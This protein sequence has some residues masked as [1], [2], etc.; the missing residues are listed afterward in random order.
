MTQEIVFAA[1]CFWGV[2][3]Y[4]SNLN[5]VITAVSGYTA[6]SYTH[7]TYEQVL[8]YRNDN[9]LINHTEAVQVIYD[10]DIIQTIDLVKLFWQLHNPTQGNRQGNDVGNNY[11]SGIYW[12]CEK[13]KEI[14]DITKQIYQQLLN[15]AGFK[16]ITT[17]VQQL[18]IFY[19]AEKYHQQYLI[20]TLMDIAPIIP[21]V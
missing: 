1:G 17:E 15:D 8:Q 11:R 9:T 18:D 5:G 2:E 21:Q 6:G 4:F 14:I 7:P 19:P 10:D 20:K 13:Q 16:E 3:K 12:S